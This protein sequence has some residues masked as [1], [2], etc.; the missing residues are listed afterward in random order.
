MG[1]PFASKV[2]RMKLHPILRLIS[3]D[4]GAIVAAGKDSCEKN[5]CIPITSTHKEIIMPNK[6]GTGPEGK[7]QRCRIPGFK[8]GQP[9]GRGQGQRSSGGGRSGGDTGFARRQGQGKKRQRNEKQ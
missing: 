1:G 5:N 4:A 7:G 9:G 2:E 6:D 8:K 3:Q